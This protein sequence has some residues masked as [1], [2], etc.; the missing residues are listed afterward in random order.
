MNG[1]CGLASRQTDRQ[2]QEHKSK[3]EKYK[4]FDYHC[5]EADKEWI[6]NRGC[7]TTE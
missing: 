7:Y 2:A 6:N 4:A 5:A 3:L 1:L